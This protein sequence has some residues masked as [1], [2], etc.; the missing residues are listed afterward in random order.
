MKLSKLANE[1]I[2]LKQSMGMRFRT[3]SVT[4]NAFC[5]TIG[6]IDIAQVTANSVLN[7]L[8]GKGPI[9]AFWHRKYEALRRFYKFVLSRGHI[10][11]SPLPT[12]IPKRP[13]PFQPY[14]YTHDQFR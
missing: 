1:Y 5:R 7:Y 6:D 2:I 13:E 12:I 14:I 9:T 8:N 10:S 11:T 4:L 3:E